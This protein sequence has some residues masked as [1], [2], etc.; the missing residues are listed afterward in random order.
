M[1]AQIPLTRGAVALVDE[2]DAEIVLRYRWHSMRRP[3]GILYARTDVMGKSVLM[4]RIIMGCSSPNVIDHVD[5]DGLNNQRANLRICTQQMNCGNARKR[6]SGASIYKGIFRH[7]AKWQASIGC[8]G[9]VVHLG[10]FESEM[11]A[12]LAYDAA[13]REAFSTFAALNFPREGEQS[14]LASHDA[15]P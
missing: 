5:G 15:H 4:H 13:A 7:R 8:D 6:V 12:A 10:T 9:K 11:D 14:A 3:N 2:C 1:V